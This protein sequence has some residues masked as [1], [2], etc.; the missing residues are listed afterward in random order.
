MK[1]LFAIVIFLSAALHLFA[2]DTVSYKI[3]KI[4][5]WAFYGWQYPTVQVVAANDR[6]VHRQLNLKCEILSYN[7]RSLYELIQLGTVNPKDSLDMAFSF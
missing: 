1:K 3:R 4:E 7:G 2:A 6:G 5:N